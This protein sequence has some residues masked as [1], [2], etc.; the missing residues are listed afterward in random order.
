MGTHIRTHPAIDPHFDWNGSEETLKKF[1][2]SER[3]RE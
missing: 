3:L 1:D 2:E